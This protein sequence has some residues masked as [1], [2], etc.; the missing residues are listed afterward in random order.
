MAETLVTCYTNMCPPHG[1]DT[2]CLRVVE[3]DITSTKRQLSNLISLDQVPHKRLLGPSWRQFELT[4][5]FLH[6]FPDPWLLPS[7]QA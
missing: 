5:P 3:W 1:D 2:E 6:F 4:L 7:V